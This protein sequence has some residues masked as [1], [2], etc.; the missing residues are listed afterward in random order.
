MRKLHGVF[1]LFSVFISAAF[2]E[3][4]VLYLI[5]DS[6]VESRESASADQ[7]QGWGGKI[8]RYFTSSKVTVENHALGGTSSR[9]FRRDGHWQKVLDKI[10]SGDFV[11]MQFGHNDGGGLNRNK[12]KASIKGMGDETE[13]VKFEEEGKTETVHSYGWY[14]KQYIREAKEKGATV[15]VCSPVPRCI[16]GDNGKCGRDDKGYGGWSRQAAKDEGVWF[17][18]LNE[19]VAQHYDKVGDRDEVHDM[20]FADEHTHTNRRGAEQNAACVISGLR[21]L[22]NCPLYNCMNSKALKIRAYQ[23]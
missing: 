17:I 1:L 15:I 10:K 22:R 18:N 7:Q 9:T 23:E 3:T 13:E 16:W 8:D 4:P 6:T 21:G 12:W 14:M 2:A 5:G 20:Y 19:I 11:M